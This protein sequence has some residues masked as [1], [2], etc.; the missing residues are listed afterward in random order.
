M[1][2]VPESR[3]GGG[4]AEI[5]LD[6]RLGSLGIR[7]VL[8]QGFSIHQ[9]VGRYAERIRG[10]GRNNARRYQQHE[11]RIG[12]CKIVAAD[13]HRELDLVHLDGAVL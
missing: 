9:V 3:D 11:L 13:N 10:R 1:S 12:Q 2:R 5:E 6:E 8:V 4:L 7:E